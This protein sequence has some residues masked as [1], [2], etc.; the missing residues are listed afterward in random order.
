[1]QDLTAIGITQPTV[2]KRLTSEI[3]KL[4][5]CDGIPNHKPVSLVALLLLFLFIWYFS[6]ISCFYLVFVLLF[7]YCSSS[8]F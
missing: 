6:F 7:I 5:I 8:H 1:L 2:R 4:H 3:S